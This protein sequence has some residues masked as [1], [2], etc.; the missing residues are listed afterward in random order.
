MVVKQFCYLCTHLAV[1]MIAE[2]FFPKRNTF[3]YIVRFG[4][5]K[6]LGS[7]GSERTWFLSRVPQKHIPNA[8]AAVAGPFF[9]LEISRTTR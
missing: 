8:L 6:R 5:I 4:L 1:D 7:T 3:L 9:F 2:C